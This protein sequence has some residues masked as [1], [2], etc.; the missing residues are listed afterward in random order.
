MYYKFILCKVHDSSVIGC[1]KE[2][3]EVLVKNK[4]QQV[5]SSEALF[6]KL[7][8][9]PAPNKKRKGAEAEK[10]ERQY[11]DLKLAWYFG[12]STA[13]LDA[14]E[15]ANFRSFCKSLNQEVCSF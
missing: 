7:Y 15:D 12:S 11:Q 2:G 14:V 13:P 1:D 6:Q 5:S 4:A 8:R 10:E 9:L 3:S